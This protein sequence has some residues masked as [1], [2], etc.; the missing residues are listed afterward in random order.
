MEGIIVK[1]TGSNYLIKLNN[2]DIINAKLRGKIKTFGLKSTNPVVV[3]DKVKVEKQNNDYLITSIFDRKN[4][5]CRKSVNLS[6][7]LHIIAAN[8]DQCLLMVSFKNPKTHI[9]FIDRFLVAAESFRIPSVIGIN[10][11]DLYSEEDKNVMNEFINVYTKIGYK[12]LPFSISKK[13]NIDSLKQELNNKTTLINGNS[14]VGKSSLIKLLMPEIDIKISEI[15][16]YHLQGK[17]TTTFAEMY[18]INNNTNIID[19]PGIKAFGLFDIDKKVLS[20]YFPEM[21]KLLNECKFHNC[22]HLNEPNCAVKAAVENGEIA[23]SRYESY[24]AMYFEDE[25]ENYRGLNY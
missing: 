18:S 3:G 9:S 16:D 25:N 1:S 12:C 7:R 14:G 17:H 22:L 23:L 6:K 8:I 15:S 10:K 13:T 19:T 5:I 21:R 20:H 11:I 2:G 24:V 4:Y